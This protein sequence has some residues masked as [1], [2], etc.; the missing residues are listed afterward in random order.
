MPLRCLLFLLL[1]CGAFSVAR[2]QVQDYDAFPLPDDPPYMTLY[3]SLITFLFTYEAPNFTS[4]GSASSREDKLIHAA[5]E[6]AASFVASQGAIR[7]AGLEA[8]LRVLR[9]RPNSRHYSDLQL[10]EAIML[11]A[12]PMSATK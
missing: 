8:A 11:H 10:A 4:E 6:D 12:Y 5:G 2:A 7:G 3:V 1:T 9:E